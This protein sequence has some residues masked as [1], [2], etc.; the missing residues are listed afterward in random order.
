M[1]L[2]FEI[3]NNLIL[4]LRSQAPDLLEDE[5]DHLF[6]MADSNKVSATHFN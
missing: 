4:A 3:S 2:G 6:S 1:A 5:I